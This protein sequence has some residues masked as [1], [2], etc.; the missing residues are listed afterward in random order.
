M[1]MATLYARTALPPRHS[2]KNTA[3]K[4]PIIIVA[5]TIIIITIIAADWT[6]YYHYLSI[7]VDAA[8]FQHTRNEMSINYA[9]NHPEH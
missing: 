1:C 8:R 7:L 4:A 3:K 9:N 6:T 2:T 5:I